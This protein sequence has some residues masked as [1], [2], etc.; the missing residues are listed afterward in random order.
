M[1]NKKGEATAA[2]F[3]QEFGKDK[4]MFVQC[5]VTSV[6]QMKSMILHNSAVLFSTPNSIHCNKV[7]T[8]NSVQCNKVVQLYF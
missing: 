1:Q 7:V 6:D 5:D 8:P 4:A 2:E 3:Q